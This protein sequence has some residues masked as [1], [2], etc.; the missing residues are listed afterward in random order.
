MAVATSAFVTD[1]LVQSKAFCFCHSLSGYGFAA[2]DVRTRCSSTFFQWQSSVEKK[3]KGL[4]ITRKGEV[5]PHHKN[6]HEENGEK[7]TT[8]HTHAQVVAITRGQQKQTE[9]VGG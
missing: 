1:V 8:K 9:M 6:K 4:G 5:Y 7:T 3:N 2:M